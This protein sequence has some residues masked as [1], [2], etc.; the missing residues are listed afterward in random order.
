M[1]KEY[2]EP[3]SNGIVQY[4]AVWWEGKIVLKKVGRKIWQKP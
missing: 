3:V 4:Y 1:G 2:N